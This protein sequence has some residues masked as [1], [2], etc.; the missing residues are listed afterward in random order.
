MG[1]FLTVLESLKCNFIIVKRI[2]TINIYP[3]L[4]NI[5]YKRQVN[6]SACYRQ[7]I[8]GLNRR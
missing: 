4:Y 2:C 3:Y 8:A 1:Q 7:M 5:Y 6:S